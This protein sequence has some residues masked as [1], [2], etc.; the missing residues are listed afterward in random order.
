MCGQPHSLYYFEA[1]NA[2]HLTYDHV[3]F[4]M[5]RIRTYVPFIPNL[6]IPTQHSAKVKQ[7]R[8]ISPPTL[9]GD[10]MQG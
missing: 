2:L 6:N 5:K 3:N 4:K 9:F 10:D 8:H 1:T 7:I